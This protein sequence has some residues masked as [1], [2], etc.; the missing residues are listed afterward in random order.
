[1]TIRC[2]PD[3]TAASCCPTTAHCRLHPSLHTPPPS[4]HNR[5]RRRALGQLRHPTPPADGGRKVPTK[6]ALLRGAGV[7]VG[8]RA[9]RRS[10]PRQRQGVTHTQLRAEAGWHNSSVPP[11]IRTNNDTALASA[12]VNL[13]KRWGHFWEIRHL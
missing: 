12:G 7:A 6:F 10:G 2:P 3:P 11:Q 13:W 5:R 8:M 1:M 4:R 9:V